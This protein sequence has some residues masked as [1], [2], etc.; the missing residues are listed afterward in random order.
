M[1]QTNSSVNKHINSH[2][3]DYLDYYCKLPHAPNY[4]VLLKGE[5][6]AG[7]TWFIK[8]YCEKLKSKKQKYLYVSLYGITNF[9]EIGD[10]FFRQLH[11]ILSSKEMAI[12]AQIFKGLLRGTLRIDLNGDQ[13]KDDGTVNCQIPDINFSEYLKNTNEN[14]LVFDDLERC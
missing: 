12:T 11:P 5:W 8:K 4:A 10:A 1:E 3:E 7:K 6:G 13:K 9:S 2:V 14:I